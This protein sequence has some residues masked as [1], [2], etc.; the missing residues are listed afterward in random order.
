[1]DFRKLYCWDWRYKIFFDDGVRFDVVDYVELL[2]AEEKLIMQELV[3]YF[4]SFYSIGILLDSLEE[5]NDSNYLGIINKA[6]AKKDLLVY[7]PHLLRQDLLSRIDTFNLEY[8]DTL[9]EL[10]EYSSSTD[11]SVDR[12][13]IYQI[14][15]G[16]EFIKAL[17]LKYGA[18]GTFVNS[19]PITN[20]HKLGDDNV[21]DYFHTVYS[22][23]LE[24]T[25][26]IERFGHMLCK[27]FSI[28][29]TGGTGF[30]EWWVVDLLPTLA[31]PKL[32]LY[33]N[34]DSMYEEDFKYTVLHEVYPGHG[35]FYSTLNN[36]THHF[37]HGAIA[38]I[39]G[40]ATFIEWNYDESE[41]NK[42]SKYNAEVLLKLL[43]T[44]EQRIDAVC[45]RVYDEKLKQGYSKDE[46]LRNVY[47]IS[48]LP[49]FLESYYIGALWFEYFST[50]T[51]KNARQ[52]LEFL[53]ERN[54]G[55]FFRLW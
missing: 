25:T 38:L 42:L 22:K 50:K 52:I 30:A 2:S 53:S 21:E 47:Y 36:N 8:R 23:L 13:T 39:E 31:K 26:N 19:K 10:L 24:E 17:Q 35:H 48:M 51:N 40:W 1:M 45:Q 29:V 37:D 44:E 18:E 12:M 27:D 33:N 6:V 55:D 7:T 16:S 49:G 9:L 3:E 20:K 11:Y 54:V 5:S 32:V 43:L 28:D 34:Q 4:M 15:F 14:I 46:A 41:Y